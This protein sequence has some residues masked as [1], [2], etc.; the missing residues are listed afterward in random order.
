MERK[1]I[2]EK[3]TGAERE[4]A[5]IQN[6][7][8]AI[9]TVDV[10]AIPSL[11]ETMV[12][13]TAMKAEKAICNLRHLMYATLNITKRELMKKIAGVHGI[14]IN[15]D[16]D[17][18]SVTFPALLQKKKKTNRFEFTIDPLY[19]ALEEFFKTNDMIRFKECAVVFEHIYNRNFPQRRFCDFDNIE[20]KPVLD[21]VSA[22]TMVDDSSKFCDVFHTTGYAENDC[23]KIKIMSKNTFRE[24]LA[25]Q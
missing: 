10:D 6:M 25:K 18:F 11:Y 13:D 24:W 8:K 22:F 5:L 17:I 23:T 15:Y 2:L 7:I 4:F 19:F 9:A 1:I 16:G 20:L 3:L 12:I 14:D 21:T